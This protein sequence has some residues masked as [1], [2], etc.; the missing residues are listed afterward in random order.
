MN[1]IAQRYSH[2]SQNDIVK[3]INSVHESLSSSSNIPQLELAPSIAIPP[4]SQPTDFLR[5]HTDDSV[6]P[7]CKIKIAHGTTTLAFRFQG[8]IVVAVDSRATAGNWIASQTVNK[9]IRINPFLLGTMAGGAADCQFWETWLGTQCRLHELREKERI[10]V[11]AAS[12]I[13][14]NL[15]YQYK[16]MGL[17]MGTMVCGHTAKEGPTIYYVDS[18]G[19]RLKGDVFCVGSGQT[20]AYGVLDSE[21]KWDLSVEDALYL[22]KRS[23]LAATHRDAYSGGSVN[24]YHVTEQGWT[25]HG[26]FNVG[27]LFWEVKEKEQSFVNVDG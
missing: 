7:D 16:G 1:S 12:K 23:I 6:N 3:E 8:G 13:L 15:V 9:V 14:S 11:A 25:Y 24:L 22:G 18:D 5:A 27:D 20:F 10:S 17:S 4:I 26:N 21:Y 2:A 19:T